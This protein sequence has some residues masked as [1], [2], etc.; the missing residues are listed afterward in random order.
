[1]VN[2]V[3]LSAEQEWPLSDYAVVLH[4]FDRQMFD[5]ESWHRPGSFGGMTITGIW[6]N[7][8]IQ[9]QTQHR[10]APRDQ[11]APIRA[12]WELPADLEPAR[13]W[14]VGTDDDI[15]AVDTNDL[16]D[17]NCVAVVRCQP[18]PDSVVLAVAATDVAAAEAA[19]RPRLGAR[20][21]VV[22]SRWSKAELDAVTSTPLQHWVD[23]AIEFIGHPVDEHFQSSVDV[24]L[25][26]VTPALASWAESL[27]ADILTVQPTLTPAAR[28]TR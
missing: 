22:H 17:A 4:G 7:G 2:L 21:C 12:T 11:S 20:V 16:R 18:R 1:M 8:S 5:L 23:W 27:P 3:F 25:L 15:H 10:L 13:G 24:T 28:R 26:A 9:V 19:W 6:L 14:P